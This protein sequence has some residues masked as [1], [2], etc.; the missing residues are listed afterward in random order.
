M[1]DIKRILAQSAGLRAYSIRVGILNKP[2]RY[3]STKYNIH[4][5]SIK[6]YEESPI[7]KS[8]TIGRRIFE[9]YKQEGVH[10]SENWFFDGVGNYPISEEICI[11]LF[12]EHKDYESKAYMDILLFKSRYPDAEIISIEDTFNSPF[13][14][15]GDHVGF[16][17]R[18][19]N[20]V[21]SLHKV[22]CAIEHNDKII[23]RICTKISNTKVRIE[24]N[25]MQ[26]KVINT[27][28]IAPIIFHRPAKKYR[29]LNFNINIL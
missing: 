19:L 18:K 24:T 7:I 21:D 3:F 22:L 23:V 29:I 28:F 9:A 2:K 27:E 14:N 8:H 20:Q 15:Y 5:N 17:W 13:Y 11:R 16:I 6:R 1:S 10:V 12:Y 4:S 25:S 26:I